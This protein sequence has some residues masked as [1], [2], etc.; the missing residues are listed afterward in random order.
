MAVFAQSY[1]PRR[2][3]RLIG[4]SLVWALFCLA[5]D[6]ATGPGVQFGSLY[7]IPVVVAAWESQLPLALG[8]SLV[9]P[10]AEFLLDRMWGSCSDTGEELF[11]TFVRVIAL[12]VLALLADRYAKARARADHRLT[13]PT[14][15]TTRCERCGR[16]QDVEG[17]WWTVDERLTA[18]LP[19]PVTTSPCPDCA[20][21]IQTSEVKS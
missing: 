3:W 14:D 8:I 2:D 7:A 6:Y 4:F 11:T 12:V 16:V 17:A 18:Q 15:H 19:T 21:G 5:A 1:R 10:A 13:L 20:R 9:L